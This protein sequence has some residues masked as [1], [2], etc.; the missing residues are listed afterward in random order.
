MRMMKAHPT[1]SR[2]SC[3]VG[4]VPSACSRLP[5]IFVMAMVLLLIGAPLAWPLSDEELT[6]VRDGFG[7]RRDTYL[8]EYLHEPFFHFEEG[9]EACRGKLGEAQWIWYPGEDATAKGHVGTRYFRRVFEIPPARS[10][11]RAFCAIAVDNSCN[12]SVNGREAGWAGGFNRASV[13][14][15]TEHIEPGTNVLAIAAHNGG[16][17][18]N[19]AGV[20]GLVHIEFEEGAPLLFVTDASWRA[21][22]TSVAGWE[23]LDFKGGDWPHAEVLGPLGCTPWGEVAVRLDVRVS[24]YVFSRLT[25]A[26]A[27]LRLGTDTNRANAAVIEA[28]EQVRREQQSSGE[29]GLHWMGGVF[30]RI[31]GLFG[32]RGSMKGRLSSEAAD[33]IRRLFADWARS[34]SRL[35]D[36]DPELSWRLWGSENHSAQRDATRWAA[37]RMVALDPRGETYRYDD[38]STAA[39]QLTA[40]GTFLKRYFRERVKRGMLVE[41]SPSGYG[42]RTLQGWHNIYDFT[43]DPE[44]KYLVKSALDVWWADWAQ[45]QLNGMRGGGKTRLYPGA[46]GLSGSD[47]NRAMSWFYLGRGKPAHKHETLPVIATTT[48]RL[49]LVVMD[50]ALDPEGRGVYETRSR[51]LGRLAES[52]GPQKVSRDEHPV[53]DVDPEYGGLI[54]YTYCTPEF[55]VGCLMMERRPRDYWT[56]VSAQ[57]RWHGVIFDGDLDSTIYPRCDTSRSTSNAHWAVQNKGTLIAQKLRGAVT[58]GAMRVCFSTDLER[59]EAGG[60]IFAEAEGAYAAVKIAQGGW[61]WVDKR[62]LRCEE[63]YAPVILE[64]VRKQEYGNSFDAFKAA[65]LRQQIHLEDGVLRY[66]GLQEDAGQFTFYTESER[67]PELDGEPINL[68]PDYAFES[69]FLKEAWASGVVHIQKGGRNLLIDVREQRDGAALRAHKIRREDTQ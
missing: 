38:G 2:R 44:L 68:R 8:T 66:R 67:L 7:A 4:E 13:V 19:P 65:I 15:I 49:P 9:I 45:E 34:E 62:W 54:R 55:I 10:H 39:E 16:D 33:A 43:D 14:D 23:A 1:E 61:A 25:F 52:G 26:L 28:V 27:A 30:H 57:N 31:Y 35:A 18:P 32:P 42:S 47:R 40:W 69:P 53:Y 48:Y 46:Y 56:K 37:A 24:R 11:E 59:H 6:A 50:I 60:W 51:R 29:F 21:S 17:A 58:T 64:V 3:A 63:E 5:Y 41:I 36:A 12:I 20:L 22:N